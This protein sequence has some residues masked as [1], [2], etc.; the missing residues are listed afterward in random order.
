MAANSPGELTEHNYLLLNLNKENQIE[1]T[2]WIKPGKV[3]RETTLTTGGGKACVDFAAERGLQYIEFDAG[4]YGNE[5]DETSDATTVTLDPKRSK[6]PLDL[7][8]VIR[9]AKS[10]GIGVWL[11]VNQKALTKQLDEILPL[12]KSW[13]VSGVKYGFVNVGNQEATTWLHDAIRKAAKYQLMVDVHD[14]YR[15]T[16]WERTYPNLMTVEGI[17]GNEEM[18][19]AEMNCVTALTRT[20]AGRGDYTHCWYSDRIKTT[21]AHQL[22]SVVVFYS[23]I[24]FLF[25]Y[26]K[27]SQFQGEPE[28]DFWKTI[29]TV[30]DDTRVLNGEAGKYVTFARRTGK[31]WYLGTLNA[32]KRRT[33]DVPLN[34]LD[35][36]TQYTATIYT[37]AAPDGTTPRKV[38]IQHQTVN[39]Q[40]VLHFDMANN[41][42]AAVRITP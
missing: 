29:P 9:Y 19:T 31:E 33:L 37:D 2:S 1:N 12:Y 41:G 3:I 6:G 28:L 36:N 26:D 17:R 39:F 22:A 18:P 4:W 10:K 21:H 8:E 20:I 14:E 16:G 7:Q 40:T 15:P 25:W 42:G 24:Q 11:Y 27:P 35:K 34:F 13:G 38:A 5:Y 32:E 23:P 30:W